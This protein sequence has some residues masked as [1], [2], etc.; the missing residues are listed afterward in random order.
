MWN[1][2]E[3]KE[4]DVFTKSVLEGIARVEDPN[5]NYAYL[6]ESTSIEYITQRKCNLMQ[7]GG[8]LDSKGYGIA[9]PQGKRI[10]FLLYE[11]HIQLHCKKGN[12]KCITE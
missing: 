7:V 10:P 11:R 3:S 8:L 2:M 9:T 5:D 4:P 1:F 12:Y 6:M